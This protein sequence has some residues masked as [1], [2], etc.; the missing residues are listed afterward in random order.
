MFSRKNEKGSNAKAEFTTLAKRTTS[1]TYI[2]NITLFAQAIGKLLQKNIREIIREKKTDKHCKSFDTWSLVSSLVFC[3]FLGCDSVRDLQR[4]NSATGQ[5]EPPRNLSHPSK[6]TVAYRNA[7]RSSA[8]FWRIF[9]A[10]VVH[11]GQQA[12]WQRAKF[13]FKMP[14]KR[15]DS[16]T[17]TLALLL[18]EWAHY[19]TREDAVKTQTLLDHDRLISES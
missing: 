11:F 7:N 15:L 3:R 1:F 14:V 8:V 19:T 18:Y 6:S 13:R 2:A 5:L 10:L 9:Y 12:A 16:S 4:V 17:I